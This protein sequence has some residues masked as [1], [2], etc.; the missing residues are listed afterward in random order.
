MLVE[1]CTN[2]TDQHCRTIFISRTRGWKGPYRRPTKQIVIGKPLWQL[3]PN[4]GLYNIVIV[5]MTVYVLL[6]TSTLHRN[7]SVCDSLNIYV[8]PLI[9]P[10]SFYTR[11]GGLHPAWLLMVS[12]ICIG[13]ACLCLQ[14]P[15]KVFCRIHANVQ[16]SRTRQVYWTICCK[17]V[18]LSDHVP[19]IQFRNA[20][21]F[22]LNPCSKSP[23][24][25]GPRI[26]P[27]CPSI[28]QIFWIFVKWIIIPFGQHAKLDTHVF[29]TWKIIHQLF[30]V[31]VARC[32]KRRPL[33][34]GP[35]WGYNRQ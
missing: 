7:G 26:L 18:Q 29:V 6:P 24:D 13:Q 3:R 32:S 5:Y 1:P 22:C 19:R 27:K 8:S 12:R 34:L 14:S 31:Q 21:P 30:Q 11:F 15:L 9:L 28:T 35:L 2:C 16:N 4:T 10:S 33:Y 23:D 17:G 20:T 25:C